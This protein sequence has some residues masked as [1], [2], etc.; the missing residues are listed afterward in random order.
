[1]RALK[2]FLLMSFTVVLPAHA[3]PADDVLLQKTTQALYDAVASGDAKPWEAALAD[4][5]IY[6]SEDGDVLSK[7]E[8]IKGLGPL[9]AGFSG[10]IKLR[11]FS[12]RYAGDDAAVTHY[13]ADEWEVVFGQHLKTTY[14]STDSWR[15]TPAGWKMFATETTVVHRDLDPV[16]VDPKAFAPLVGE[17]KLSPETKSSYRVFLKDGQLYG[18]RDEKSATRL[19]PLSPLVYFQA[20]SIHTMIFVADAKGGVDEVREV[21]KYNELAYKRVHPAAA[22]D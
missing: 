9:P 10:G 6:T 15:R 13:W 3:A 18:G 1:M 8:L 20:G 4:D 19:I 16:A 7:A 12:V 5:C 17:Y 11:D 2:L 14:I 22:M 21:H